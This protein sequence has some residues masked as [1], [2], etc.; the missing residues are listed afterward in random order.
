MIFNFEKMKE[1]KLENFKGGEKYIMAKMY[2]DD[3]N[4]LSL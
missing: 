1:E 3:N 4:R 2:V